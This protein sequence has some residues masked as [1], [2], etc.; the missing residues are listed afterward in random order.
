MSKLILKATKNTPEI[1]F[2]PELNVFDVNGISTP[3][4]AFEFY[5]TL[6]QW[7]NEQDAVIA[8]QAN[9]KFNMPYFNSATMKAILMVLERIKAAIDVGKIWTIEWVVEDDDEFMLDAAESFESILGMKFKI[10]GM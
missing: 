10:T 7:I 1:L 4:N 3:V 2:D 5:Q 9:F 8:P 6:V